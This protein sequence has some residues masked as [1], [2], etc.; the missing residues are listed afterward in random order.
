MFTLH[1]Y[2]TI[3]NPIL[4][5]HNFDWHPP[6]KLHQCTTTF[7][8]CIFFLQNSVCHVHFTLSKYLF[9]L[10]IANFI[11]YTVLL[12]NFLKETKL[13]MYISSLQFKQAR[14]E[15]HSSKTKISQH[16]CSPATY[17]SLLCM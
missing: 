15:W 3:W 10:D 11:Q 8:N 17:K 9:G 7:Y 2:Q 13:Y 12:I 16:Y 6:T 4:R 14:R 1:R 5:N